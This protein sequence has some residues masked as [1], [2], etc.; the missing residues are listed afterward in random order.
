M[1]K[2]LRCA[3]YM[4][5]TS[6]IIWGFERG[7]YELYRNHVYIYIYMWCYTLY[8]NHIKIYI[9][10]AIHDKTYLLNE[11]LYANWTKCTTYYLKHKKLS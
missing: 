2:D 4:V 11:K 3:G 8:R 9:C 1:D 5:S 7:G 10:D 6:M